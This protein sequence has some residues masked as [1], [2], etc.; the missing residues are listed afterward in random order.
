MYAALRH[1]VV[2]GRVNQ[3]RVR[4]GE[5]ELPADPDDLVNHMA[6]LEA[7]LDGSYWS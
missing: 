1:G 5:Q 7:M 2:M 4:F 3:R 6:T